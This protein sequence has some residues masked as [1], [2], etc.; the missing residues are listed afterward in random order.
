[1]NASILSIE[2]SVT[3]DPDGNQPV[4]RRSDAEVPARMRRMDR[5]V[6]LASAAVQD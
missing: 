5:C 6:P 1:M 3:D 2:M 4:F